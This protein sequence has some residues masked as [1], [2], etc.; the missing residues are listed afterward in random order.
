MRKI[1]FTIVLTALTYSACTCQTLDEVIG[2]YVNAAGGMDK[3]KSVKTVKVTAHFVQGSTNVPYV[4]YIKVP[5]KSKTEITRQGLTMQIGYNGSTGWRLNP[6]RGVKIPEKLTAEETKDMKKEADFEGGLVDYESKGSKAEYLG[7]DDFEG[8]DV[9][10]IKLTDSDGE[11]T[12]YYIDK[13][14]NLV[15]KESVKR[16]MKEKEQKTDTYY[17]AYKSV[18]GYMLP[19]SI[20]VDAGTGNTQKIVIDKV[21]FNIPIQDEIFNMPEAK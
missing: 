14:T 15:L 1:S 4:E 16:K 18:D 21:E 13:I 17:A 7:T 2:M 20:E 10:K 8:S 9:Y 6:F 3:I 19:F 5:D 11:V 12:T